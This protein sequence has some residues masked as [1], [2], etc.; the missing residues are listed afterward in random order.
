MVIVDGK[1]GSDESGGREY[2]PLH[3]NGGSS[4]SYL[5]VDSL[6]KREL[7]QQAM[8]L[9]DG[10]VPMDCLRIAYF[11]YQGR[12]LR[13]HANREA[14]DGYLWLMEYHQRRGMVRG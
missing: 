10:R 3:K 13:E 7:L 6:V 5:V 2:S 8:E 14:L 12:L 1:S 11:Y 4:L 9:Y